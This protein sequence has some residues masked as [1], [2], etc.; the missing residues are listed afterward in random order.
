MISIL[1]TSWPDQWFDWIVTPSRLAKPQG[2]AFKQ[3]NELVKYMKSI[4]KR[5]VCNINLVN[6]NM[7]ISGITGNQIY[8]LVKQ[9]ISNIYT[10]LI[11]WNI[12]LSCSRLKIQVIDRA[13][14]AVWE[15][16]NE[17]VKYMKSIWKRCVCNINLVNQNMLISSFSY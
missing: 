4:W 10:H 3:L 11:R 7:S 12:V 6:Q 17:L 13:D 9:S 15:Q 5:C 14:Q 16:L 1:Y 2:I 8:K